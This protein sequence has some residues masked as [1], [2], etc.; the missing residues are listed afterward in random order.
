MNRKQLSVALKVTPCTI[1]R[2]QR[3]GMPCKKVNLR[4][5]SWRQEFDLV[6]STAWLRQKKDEQKGNKSIPLC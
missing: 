1:F 6:E 5:T 4:G 3:Q 2:W